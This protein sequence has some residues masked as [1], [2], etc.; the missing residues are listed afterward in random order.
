[1]LSSEYSRREQF[2]PKFPISFSDIK[3]EIAKEQNYKHQLQNEVLSEGNKGI[4][5]LLRKL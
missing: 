2:E 4:N 3:L 1:L 5:Q